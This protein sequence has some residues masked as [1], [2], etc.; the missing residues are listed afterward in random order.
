[1]HIKNNEFSALTL[2]NYT[3]LSQNITSQKILDFS[4]YLDSFSQLKSSE[5]NIF[6]SYL[7]FQTLEVPCIV[8]F[9]M[10]MELFW[11]L[12]LDLLGQ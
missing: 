9:L 5:Y 11:I 2:L 6:H 3:K 7:I 8:V 12:T 4:R 10:W 1:M